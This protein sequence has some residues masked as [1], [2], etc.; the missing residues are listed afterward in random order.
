MRFTLQ[1]VAD[2]ETTV[3]KK[4]TCF[5]LWLAVIARFIAWKVGLGEGCSQVLTKQKAVSLGRTDIDVLQYFV[6]L[7]QRKK[8]EYFPCRCS[9]G[10][11]IF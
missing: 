10:I 11:T 3:L 5:Y 7:Q 2:N 1:C 6:H 4:F 8:R 9:F